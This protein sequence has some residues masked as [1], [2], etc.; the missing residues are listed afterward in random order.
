[1][2]QTRHPVRNLAA[3]THSLLFRATGGRFGRK[4]RGAPVLVLETRGRKTG[5]PRTVPLLY[6]EDAGDWVVMASSGGDPLHPAWFKNLEADRR[7][8]VITDAG[9]RG[10]EAFVTVGGERERL[11]A[12]MTAIWSD[13]E[14]Y[15]AR[16]T[17]ELPLVRLRPQG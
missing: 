6:I 14:T 4:V 1:M 11:F 10:V 13:F 3:R 8:T 16:T 15:S 5:K 7:A 17:R 2:K 12:G 9:R